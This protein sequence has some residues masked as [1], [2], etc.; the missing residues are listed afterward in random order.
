MLFGSH[1][2]SISLLSLLANTWK[3][4]LLSLNVLLPVRVEC[5]I[6]NLGFRPAVML[7]SLIALNLILEGEKRL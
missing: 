7:L 5:E 4:N 3:Q 2:K 6:G 1:G